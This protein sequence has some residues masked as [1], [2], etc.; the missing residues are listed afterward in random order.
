MS[1][2]K[3]ESLTTQENQKGSQALEKG[4]AG[5]EVNLAALRPQPSQLRSLKSLANR[6]CS[7]TR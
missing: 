5:L 6:H 7:N 4:G 3:P 1:D 2:V